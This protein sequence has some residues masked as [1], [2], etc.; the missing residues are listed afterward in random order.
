MSDQITNYQ[1]PACGGPLHFSNESQD[2]AC[3]YCDSHFSVADIEAY[4]A[5][6]DEVAAS[7]VT[8]ESNTWEMGSEEEW[9]AAGDQMRVYNCPSC[10]AE[11]ICDE[12]TAASSCPYCGNPTIVPGQLQGMLRPDYVIPFRLDKEAAKNALRSHYQG[13]KLLPKTFSKENHIDEI[14]GIYVPF[15]LFDGEAETDLFYNA[16]RSF[17]T[18]TRNERII[19]TE[20]Y[21]LRRAGTVA[22]SRIP[23]D[24]SSKMPDAHMDAI[25]PFDF[26]E[27][28]PFST[29]YLPG[30]F[31]DKYD[32]SVE[33]SAERADT[34]AEKTARDI[35]RQSCTGYESVREV[36]GDVRLRR[37]KVHYA[38]M[39]VWML[40]T[41][42]HGQNFLFAMNGQ[43]GKIV[44]DLPTDKGRWWGYFAATAAVVAAVVTAILTLM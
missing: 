32:V 6:K 23:V 25:E 4:Y 33:D 27:L 12:T 44:G 20:H 19:T 30:F 11:L 14:K 13:K 43:T 24:A 1:C 16:T 5:Q 9:D 2:L 26:S 3:D 42:W 39:P 35:M 7:S 31:A 10:G 29:A 34:R 28:Q 15:W 40:N 22:F 17:V 41:S 36:G 21:N 38:L 18:E 8:E 37:G